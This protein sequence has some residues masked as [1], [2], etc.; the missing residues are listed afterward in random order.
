MSC[1]FRRLLNVD[2]PIIAGEVTPNGCRVL[3]PFAGPG[4]GI[5]SDVT[6]MQIGLRTVR[7][8]ATNGLIA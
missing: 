2:A 1:P 5:P 7:H 3:D 8:R 6:V 4:K